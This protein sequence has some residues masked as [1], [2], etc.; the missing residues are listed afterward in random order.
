MHASTAVNCGLK[1]SFS[2]LPRLC[3]ER[4]PALLVKQD[5][6]RATIAFLRCWSC[7]V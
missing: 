1:A 2:S 6:S 3:C 5:D 7:Y 4:S